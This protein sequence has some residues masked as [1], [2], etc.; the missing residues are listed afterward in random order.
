M[1]IEKAGWGE[2]GEGFSN[3][4]LI[5]QDS[6]SLTAQD[7]F[8]REDDRNVIE[9]SCLNTAAYESGEL[10]VEWDIRYGSGELC[11][12][13]DITLCEWWVMCGVRYNIMGVMSYEWSERQ[14]DNYYISR[15]RW[16]LIVAG[17]KC[18]ST[19]ESIYMCI[20]LCYHGNPVVT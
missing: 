17:F 20:T 3:I 11:V 19:H 6:S 7:N 10:W 14:W 1:T 9:S 13:W 4:S 8:V 15:A 16:I 18:D 5:V 12:E 2:R